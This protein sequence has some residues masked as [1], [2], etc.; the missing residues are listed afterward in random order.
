MKPASNIIYMFPGLGAEY[1]G[2]LAAFC[3]HYPWAESVIKNWESSIDFPLLNYEPQSAR[4]KELSRQLQIH[5]LNLL[6]W[7]LAKPQAD[8]RVI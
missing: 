6:W 7:K 3:K 8:S 1:P 2:M 4:D 5:C